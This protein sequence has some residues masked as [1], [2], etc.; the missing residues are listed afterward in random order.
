[1]R[2]DGW[3]TSPSQLEAEKRVVLRRFPRV[4]GRETE[5]REPG[6]FFTFDAAG[7]ALLLTCDP[8]GTPHAMQN[9]C[10]HRS[11]RLVLEDEGSATSFV[12]RHHAWTYDLA[13]HLAR[14]G[15]VA[16]PVALER[17]LEQFADECALVR[18]PL[19]ARHGFLWVV[20]NARG[21]IDVAGVLGDLD[22]ELAA[23]GVAEWRTLIR[24]RRVVAAGWKVVMDA[25]LADGASRLAMPSAVFVLGSDVVHHVA[26]YPT[27][28]PDDVGH[29]DVVHTVLA[30]RPDVVLR[31]DPFVSVLA[32]AERVAAG[33]GTGADREG[34]LRSHA[35]FHDALDRALAPPT[36]E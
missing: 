18:Y 15:R 20:P 17:S 10:R 32:L 22:G 34:E 33:L 23:R 24:T 8:N 4:V 35:P 6:R 29:S 36:R 25:L 26:V 11:A 30:P 12:C 16:L 19:E 21:S 27:D 3:Y 31:V 14:P 28:V 9:L 7:V 13:G 2:S 1:M 5:L